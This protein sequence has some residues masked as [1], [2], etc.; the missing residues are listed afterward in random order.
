MIKFLRNN[1]LPYCTCF[2]ALLLS[3]AAIAQDAQPATP[4]A[5]E[6]PQAAQ[7]AQAASTQS[8]QSTSDQIQEITVTAQKRKES[9]K[10][11]PISISTIGGDAL[12]E[13][14]IADYDD[15]TR[16]MPSVSFAAGGGGNG[17]GEGLSIIEMRGISSTVGQATVGVYLDDTSLTVTNR[18]DGTSQPLPLDIA[19]VEVLRGPQGT[20]YGASS[21]GGTIRFITNTP[22]LDT[23]ETNLT[24]DISGTE[25]GGVN[26]DDSAVV[27]IPL[28]DNKLAL[29]I[30]VDYGSNSGY[31]DNYSS[32]GALNASGVNSDWHGALKIAALYQPS[33]DLTITPS[34]W[35]QRVDARD[36]PVFYPSL[37][38]YNQDKSVNEPSNDRL[39][40][41]SV[42]VDKDFSFA[43]LTSVSSYYFRDESRQTD[44]TYFNDVAFAEFF[45]DPTPPFTAHQAQNDAIIANIPSPVEWST[46]YQQ[47]SQ[48]LR[49]VSH[50]PAPGD[51]PLKWTAGFYYNYQLTN[52]Q[53]SEFSPG[54]NAAFEGIYGFPLSST[55]VQNALGTAPDTFAG[56]LIIVQ[57]SREE[58]MQYA[59]FGQIDYDILPDLH[60]SAGL[61]Y[62]VATTNIEVSSIGFYAGGIPT[63]YASNA[64]FYGSTPKFSLSY[65]L[66]RDA[67][68]YTTI[69]KGYRI[70]GGN[71]PDP[72]GPGNIC[73]ADYQG[74]G[75]NGAPSSYESDHLWSY[76]LGSKAY[77]A[78]RT[79]SIDA[80]GYYIQWSNI[81]QTIVLPTCGFNF[82]GNFGDAE[83][84]GGEVQIQYKAPFVH[85]LTLG[86]NSGVGRSVITRSSQPEV[87]AVGEHVLYTP[88]WTM[89]FNGDYRWSISDTLGGFIRL[90]YEYSGKSH[91]SYQ[92][93]NPNYDD[94]AY[95]VLNAG[96][97]VDTGS[98][99]ISLYGKNLANDQTIIQRPQVNNVIEGYMMR[100]LTVGLNVSKQF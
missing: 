15:L 70:G 83:S 69:A 13:R 42:T 21:M 65:D 12:S 88:D 55:I 67:N 18:Y 66:S 23:W 79:L 64:D 57:T 20:L 61:R 95:G 46:R 73:S 68:V 11:I 97:G 22:K 85:G 53:N 74:I 51:L 38:L 81:Q 84:Y 14:H 2:A 82:T 58:S 96:I 36:S 54:L 91:G 45:L 49:L 89:A 29:R 78:D 52:H 76:E 63:N 77:L 50:D 27:N 1:R 90:D 60:A 17:V 98:F 35:L 92:T 37:G 44:G 71:T 99:Q 7:T 34:L 75:V 41:P 59:G 93:D 28:I 86:L 43:H 19:R 24:S 40:I 6:S 9:T 25:H 100:P 10:D 32:S 5:S 26:Y 62:L 48:E 30:G 94:P 8:S 31:I 39:F 33:D 47:A 87:A 16:S 72:S 80:A 3:T 4:A 56:D